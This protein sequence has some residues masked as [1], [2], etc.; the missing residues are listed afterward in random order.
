MNQLFE[1]RS[2]RKMVLVRSNEM[3]LIDE[4]QNHFDGLW[5]RV[6]PGM[7]RRATMEQLKALR[8]ECA[9]R[10]ESL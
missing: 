8:E 1:W 2:V 10:L 5:K 4:F 9:A 3:L 7:T 6:S